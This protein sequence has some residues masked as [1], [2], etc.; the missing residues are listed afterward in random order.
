MREPAVVAV[1]V[2]VHVLVVDADREMRELLEAVLGYCG[3]FVSLAA[4]AAEAVAVVGRHRPDVVVLDAGMAEPERDRDLVERLRTAGR[5]PSLPVV[6]LL[7]GRDPAASGL[8]NVEFS[9]QLRKPL[10]PWALCRLLAGLARK[11]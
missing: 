5:H 7:S 2:G 8:E 3:S 10:D 11:A 4:S 1:L 6:V 9:V